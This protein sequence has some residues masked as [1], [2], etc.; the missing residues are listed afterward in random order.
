MRTKAFEKLIESEDA[1]L[2][3]LR[4][5][6]YKKGRV[7]CHACNGRSVYRMTGEIRY[8]CRRCGYTFGPLTGSW[9]ATSKVELTTR[10]WLVKLSELEAVSYTHLTLPTILRV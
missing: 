2:R 4:R 9:M 6:R 7:F 1:A 5:K 8:R 3:Y 10:L